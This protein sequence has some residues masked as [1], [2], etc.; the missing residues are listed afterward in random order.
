MSAKKT[1]K[2]PIKQEPIE[3][4]QM[5]EITLESMMGSSGYGWFLAE[6]KGEL[7]LIAMSTCP[8]SSHRIAPVKQVFRFRGTGVGKATVKFVKTV[9]WKIEPPVDEITYEFE[10][11]EATKKE[12]DDLALEGF[13][14]KPRVDVKGGPIMLYN[15]RDP[16]DACARL[17]YGV[18]CKQVTDHVRTYYGVLP[19]RT[20]EH[21][22][23]YYAVCAPAGHVAPYYAAYSP[24]EGLMPV[25]A[26]YPPTECSTHPHGVI[27]KYNIP[28]ML[29]YNYPFVQRYNFPQHDDCSTPPDCC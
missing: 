10:I 2:V 3:L 4:N 22:A 15:V 21:V 1:E 8:T 18:L 14:E 12:N 9:L 26:A 7:N 25:Y 27:A 6:L 17:Y 11:I 16:H 5:F 19:E 29:K 24:T 28:P 13:V 23:P 20:A